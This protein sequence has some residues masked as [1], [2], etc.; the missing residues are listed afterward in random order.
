MPFGSDWRREI[1]GEGFTVIC[2]KA[3]LVVWA[4]ELAVTVAIWELEMFDGALYV[5]EVAVSLESEPM[6][7]RIQVTPPFDVSFV[8]VAVM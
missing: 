2:M 3:V 8:S 5:T 4:T 1:C 7:V 6:P